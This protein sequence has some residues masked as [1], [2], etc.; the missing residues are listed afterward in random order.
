MKKKP[1]SGKLTVLEQILGMLFILLAVTAAFFP[2]FNFD[3]QVSGLIQSI[4]SPVFSQIMWFVS[5]LG[6]FPWVILILSLVFASLIW[7]K[8][9]TEAYFSIF[10]S[11]GSTILGTLLKIVIHR[12][13][14]ELGLISVLV[15]LK[16]KS[17]PSGHV[18]LFT[19]F[20]GFLLFLSLYVFKNK[21]L[22]PV[23]GALSGFLV[24]TIGISR[25]YLGAHWASDVLGGYLLGMLFLI[26]TIQ[27]YKK[28]T[29]T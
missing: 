21:I 4:K 7:S 25:I 20:F 15:Q 27:L 14:P 12:P 28:A 6:N 8:M 22:G 11:I 16:D 23:I 29:N 2:Y 24:L 9:R 19:S 13:R 3:L 26:V 18:L 5:I 10:A 1:T 17:F